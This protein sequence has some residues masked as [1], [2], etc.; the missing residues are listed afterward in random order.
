MDHEVTENARGLKRF[1]PLAPAVLSGVAAGLVAA[2]LDLDQAR[3]E[4]SRPSD[5]ALL[6]LQIGARLGA[7]GALLA[8]F[9]TAVVAAGA[10]LGRRLG[11]SEHGFAAALVAVVSAP[12]LVY[13]AFR[14]F[15]GGVTAQLPA[16]PA[17]VAA[18]IVVLVALVFAGARAALALVARA[19]RRA[20]LDAI[21][22]IAA[23]ILVAASLCM[24]WC[25]ANQYR[26]LYLYLHAALAVCTLGGLTLAFQ[27]VFARGPVR[28]SV[29]VAAIVGVL[30]AA[31]ACAVAAL[32]LDLR[33]VVKVALYERTT[34]AANVV[35]L[36]SGPRRV[37]EGPR[38]SAAAR[39]ERYERERKE[40]SAAAASV[41]PAFPGAHLVLITIDALRADRLGAYGHTARRLTPRIDEL[42]SRA[43]VFERAYCTAPHSSFSISSFHTSRYLHDEAILG[44]PIDHRTLADELGAAGYETSAFYTQGIF[45]TEGDSVGCYRKKQFGFTDASHGAPRPEQLTDN[46]IAEVDRLVARGEPAF[47][48]WAHYFNVHEP[49][50][51]K[52]FGE[53]P[54][55]RYDGEILAA[56]AEVGRLI[57]YLEDKLARDAV[58]VLTADH[59]EEF[60]DHGGHYHGSSLFDEQT[61]VPLIIKTPGAAPRR[62]S[63]PV[64]LVDLAPTA[65]ALLGRQPPDGMAGRDLRPALVGGDAA[66]V[67]RPVFASVMREHMALDWPW[68][69][70]ADPSRGLYELYDLEADPR[71]LTNRYDERRGIAERL[72]D[73]TR[74][75]LDDL[76]RGEDPAGTALA[77]G[78]MRDTRALPGL[79][80]L[81]E[82]GAAPPARREE[83]LG[84]I[85]EIRAWNGIE[86]L[87]VL[88]D[89]PDAAVARAAALALVSMKIDRGRDLLRDAL[90]DDDPAVR[91]RVALALGG[92]GDAA[93][94]PALVE[95]LGRDD[96]KVRE[97]A[98][99]LLGDLR[100]PAAVEPLIETIAEERTRYLSVLAL[101][102]I[103]DP[104]AYDT[105]VDVLKYD[106]HTDIRG[107]AVVA[108]GWLELE[109]AVPRLLRVLAEEHEI[110][111]TAEALVRLGAVGE[112]KL[113]GTD[114]A[115]GAPALAGG[116]GD[117]AEK[118]RVLPEEFLERTKCAT[119]GRE[120]RLAF[121]AA[122]AEGA[123]LIVR[124]RH[125]DADK[126]A[127]IP[128]AI[129]VDGRKIASIELR[130]EEMHEARIEIG[131]DAF[132]SGKHTVEL[133]LAKAAP[134]EVD[135]FLVLAK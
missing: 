37:D 64:S 109:A 89:D 86:R 132:P 101:G 93:A 112:G 16:R 52:R 19:D 82:D 18:T 9:C 114:V 10:A 135:Y 92:L 53:A 65:L 95:A 115:K 77:L 12:A 84:L 102:K 94:V 127:A 123:T 54:R 76:S 5:V 56:D 29:A 124:A 91:D 104:R 110:K 36:T 122:A 51:S 48:V 46:V 67:P 126:G 78:R 133:Q 85:A 90:Y 3:S 71:E 81:A 108:L 4:V 20:R 41:L 57:D 100:D 98:I 68:K 6:T 11:R 35:R 43:T 83:A 25:D 14:L 80:R 121:D 129:A 21:T 96:L 50:L 26:R 7:A 107:Y 113:F 111:W 59:G 63:T 22:A 62:V 33:Q 72:L 42:A 30:A 88:V 2:A 73:E 106:T 17:L 128:L 1:A 28:R 134:F 61:R 79:F 13:V 58:I 38:P 118:E 69:L 130:G 40:R 75:W 74:L 117:C 24:R 27:I 105:L 23:A 97:N 99:R 44:R 45:F 87:E 70:V 32:T 55:D 39:R 120:A 34:T 49:Y 15:Q 66:L 119:K 31:A 125:L 8:C 103:G 60:E 116:W 47:F 131:A